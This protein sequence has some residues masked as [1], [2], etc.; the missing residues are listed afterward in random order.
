[1]SIKQTH[2]QTELKS[3]SL[4]IDPDQQETFRYGFRIAKLGFLIPQGSHSTF[5]ENAMIFPVPNTVDWLSGLVN[6]RGSVV[7][8]FDLGHMLNTDIRPIKNSVMVMMLEKRSIAFN[9]DSGHSL[10]ESELSSSLALV[11]KNFQE[12]TEKIYAYQSNHWLEFD[13][14]KCLRHYE[15]QI[16]V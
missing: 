11:P 10:K 12:Y 6:V 15:N 1:M 9:V 14:L 3:D 4:L 7:P 8:V 16:S 5:V 2:N 13:F